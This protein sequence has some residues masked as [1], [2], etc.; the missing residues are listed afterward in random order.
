MF[1]NEY[2]KAKADGSNP[3]LV[4][5]VEELLGQK[6]SPSVQV[7][8]AVV[9]SEQAIEAL[10]DVESTAK[11]LEG[12]KE[13]KAESDRYFEYVPI[14][15]I[16]K[17]KE[18]DRA[19]EKKWGSVDNTLEELVDDIQKNGIKTP[20]TLQVDRNN[21]ALVV[22]GNTRLAAAKK[23]GIKNIPVRIISGEFGSI[24]KSKAKKIGRKRDLGEMKVFYPDVNILNQENSPAKFGFTS[25]TNTKNISE[26]YH[27]AKAD[28]SN[29]ELVKAVEELLGK[30]K[31]VTP[32]VE[33]WSKDVE[34]TAGNKGGTSTKKLADTDKSA[35][36]LKDNA[37]GVQRKPLSEIHTDEKRF[38]GRDKLNEQVVNDIAENF[39]DADQDPIHIWKD[40]KDGKYYVL[41]GHHRYY[42]AKKAGRTDIKI[43]DR[44]GDFTEAQAIKFATEEANKAAENFLNLLISK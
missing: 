8:E 35:T 20:I 40:P 19:T 2:H 38:Q 1:A 33:D 14:E 39:S 27:K 10:K 29:P 36:E 37:T 15:E 25:I 43:Q 44:T 3:E 11:A 21:N 22:E 7:G 18:F 9:E 4:K 12:L 41:S 26:A 30:P 23:L 13:F 17:Y 24:N 6:Q 34:S 31:A 42:G 5:A 32:N 28:G 16:E